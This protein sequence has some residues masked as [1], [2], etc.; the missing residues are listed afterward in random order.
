M[1]VCL[2]ITANLI[3]YAKVMNYLTLFVYVSANGITYKLRI[4]SL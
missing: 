1:R 2:Q 3:I 4:K